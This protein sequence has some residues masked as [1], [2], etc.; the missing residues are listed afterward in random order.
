MGSDYN[1]YKYSFSFRAEDLLDNGHPR[2]L[3]EVGNVQV[4]SFLPLVTPWRESNQ[5]QAALANESD[6]KTLSPSHQAC[7]FTST[8]KVDTFNT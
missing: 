4:L 2:I 1:D 8:A 6:A 5:S 7:R 3:L